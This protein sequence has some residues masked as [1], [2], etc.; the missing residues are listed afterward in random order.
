MQK[1]ENTKPSS[2]STIIQI[3]VSDTGV[4]TNQLRNE[5]FTFAELCSL[6]AK[7]PPVGSKDGSYFLRGPLKDGCTTRNDANLEAVHLVIL[8]G[9]KSVCPETGEAVEGAPDPE[10]V[11]ITLKRL[12][13]PHVI[14]TTHSHQQKGKGNKYR[15]AIPV[16]R[17]GS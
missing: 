8:D 6:L 1:E 9:D 17:H 4:K 5:E 3:A 7:T 15:V 11:H 16:V 12:G 10:D 2:G 14:Y 13:V